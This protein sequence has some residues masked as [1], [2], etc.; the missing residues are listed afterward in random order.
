[1]K[2]FLVTL[3]A[4]FSFAFSFATDDVVNRTAERSFY[5]Q[6]PEAKYASWVK[7]EQSN[8]YAVRFIYDGE[9]LMA[10]FDEEGAYVAVARNMPA[11]NLPFLVKNA[12]LKIS[13]SGTVLNSEELNM[14]GETSYM[15]GIR[16]KEGIKMYRIYADGYTEKIKTIVKK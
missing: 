5:K 11:E 9:A 12:F 7:I 13:S 15:F 4:L 1:M 8:L 10:Y 14:N 16:E 2:K 6:F 3:I